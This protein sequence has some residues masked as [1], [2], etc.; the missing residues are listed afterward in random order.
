MGYTT[1]SD[2]G[3][4][5]SETAFLARCDALVKTG[6]A[7][8]GFTYCN[9][10]D[11]WPAK[12]RD[13]QQ[14]IQPGPKFPS[15]FANISAK[16]HNAGL[17]FGLYTDRGTK[18]C[19]GYP[20]SLGHEVLDAR[21]Y[22]A[23]GVDF[24]KEDNCH[25][26]GGPNDKETQLK[27]FGAMRDALN[28]TGRPVLFAVCGGGGELPWSNI[29]YFA[30][31]PFGAALANTWRIGPDTVEFFSGRHNLALDTILEGFAGPGGWND[32][33]ML[34][35]SN[36]S[37]KRHLSPAQS[38]SQFSLWAALAAPLMLSGPIGELSAW[39]LETYSNREVIAV[40]QDP[41]GEQGVPLAYTQPTGAKLILGKRLHDGSLA[42]V[43]CNNGLFSGEVE[44][45][46]SCWAKTPF[47]SGSRLQVRDLYA[48]G[49]AKT[50]TAV[51]GQSYRVQLEGSGHSVALRFSL[52]A[53]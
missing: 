28:A 52:V 23:W 40:N 21:Q 13:D 18:T 44:C 20:G 31:P 38:R 50:P 51:A 1:W 35:T 53:V 11:G 26:P 24:L 45:D 42:A 10:D 32:P 37:S 30:Q 2:M 5:V 39:D 33:D 43:F 4:D 6:L 17:K 29:S 48:K 41:L 8:A 12:S 15:G 47:P 36:P 9:I 16:L 49:P 19:G 27:E 7:S 25:A 14:R 34:L 3:I 22:A 46:T